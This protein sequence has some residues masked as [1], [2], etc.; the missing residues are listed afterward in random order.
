MNR[1]EKNRK[2]R[3]RGSA[4]KI[5]NAQSVDKIQKENKVQRIKKEILEGKRTDLL[6]LITTICLCGFGLI[7][8]C[9]ASYYECSMNEDYGYDP[10]NLMKKQAFFVI[11]G[12]LA[13]AVLWGIGYDWIKR[14]VFLIYIAGIVSIILLLT[15]L[16]V[17][18]NGATRWLRFGS[19]QFQVAELVKASVIITLAY[20]VS[21]YGRVLKPRWMML[22][23]WITGGIPTALLFVISSDL[24]SSIVVLGIIFG[25][26][27][28][29]TKTVKE[30]LAAAGAAVVFAGAYVAKIALNMPEPEE[31]EHMSYRVARIA[32]WIDPERYASQAGYQVLQSLYAIGSGGLTGKGLGNSV[33]KLGAIPEGQTDMIFSIICEELGLLGAIA[34]ISL[35]VYLLY[36]IYIVIISSKNIFGSMIAVGVL[37]HIGVQ[38]LINFLVNVNAF[39]NTGIALPFIS[40]GGTAVFILLCEI[41]LVLSI[42]RR[43][44]VR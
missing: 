27:F 17:D 31:L 38:A 30:H 13:C 11:A 23:L 15:P 44:K 33:Q 26:S 35:F 16:G 18:V 24:S 14:L 41:G 28:I 6:I 7:M 10:L 29:S 42:A 43:G 9:S 12:I 4:H 22:I 5:N 1:T 8:I 21:R 34:L 36:Q 40:Y 25:I 20:L 39:P 19:V 2:T 32:A 37:M 3:S